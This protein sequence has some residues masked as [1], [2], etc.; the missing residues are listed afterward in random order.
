MSIKPI[1]NRILI[2]S[3]KIEEKT[4]GGIILTP[5]SS[6]VS[7]N[8]SEVIAMGNGDKIKDIK[9]GDHIIHSEYSGTKVKDKNEEFTIIDFDDVLGVIN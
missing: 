5:S 9:I 4:L 3:L 2:K 1:G 6:K 8:I 7:P